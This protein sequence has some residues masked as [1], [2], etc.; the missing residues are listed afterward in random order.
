MSLQSPK[1]TVGFKLNKRIVW[2]TINNQIHFVLVNAE[3]NIIIDMDNNKIFERTVF[4]S[5]GYLKGR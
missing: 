1:A 5:S 3:E 4:I 2:I